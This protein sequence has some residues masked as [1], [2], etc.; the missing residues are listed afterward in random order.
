MKF[1]PGASGRFGRARPGEKL[2]GFVWENLTM[3]RKTPNKTQGSI[4]P[5]GRAGGRPG[6]RARAENRSVILAL[7]GEGLSQ[8][9]IARRCGLSKGLVSEVCRGVPPGRIAPGDA[10]AGPPAASAKHRDLVESLVGLLDPLVAW[11][12]AEGTLT[13]AGAPEALSEFL[14]A[15]R[16]KVLACDAR[17]LARLE[18]GNL[19][20][21]Y[22]AVASAWSERMGKLMPGWSLKV[23]SDLFGG[24]QFILIHEERRDG[25]PGWRA[26]AV[27]QDG[28]GCDL[29]WSKNREQSQAEIAQFK[30]ECKQITADTVA[31]ILGTMT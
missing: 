9:E 13:M 10:P 11:L 26:V 27:H 7:R 12:D 15:V 17:L 18:A 30:K 14:A 2:G 6:A 19:S 16:A 3:T 31:K 1:V 4:V 29:G 22:G 5:G 21:F 8:R 24:L 20:L 28:T 25:D 23:N